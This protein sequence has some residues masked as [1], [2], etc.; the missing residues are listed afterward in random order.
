M[1]IWYYW[2][3][4]YLTEQSARMVYVYAPNE[5]T[6]IARAR[7]GNALKINAFRYINGRSLGQI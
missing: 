2:C 4:S 5:E 7:V 1:T 6:A 3:V